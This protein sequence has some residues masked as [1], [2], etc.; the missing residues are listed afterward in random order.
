MK[1]HSTLLMLTLTLFLL[2]FTASVQAEAPASSAQPLKVFILIGTSN[3]AGGGGTFAEMP[4]D[5]RHTQKDV[6]VCQDK[7]F[8]PTYA[9]APLQ[10]GEW[11]QTGPE[12]S[13]AQAMVKFLGEPIGLI[14]VIQ[15]LKKGGDS[16]KGPETLAV[17]W[18]P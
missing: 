15:T 2:L 13:F 7:F 14:K 10:E 3:M 6:L 12:H 16:N 5:L 11:H 18:S 17:Y 8:H 9:W 1:T 4:G